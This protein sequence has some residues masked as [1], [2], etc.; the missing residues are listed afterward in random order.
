MCT[1]QAGEFKVVQSIM[2]SSIPLLTGWSTV[3]ELAVNHA[4]DEAT[5]SFGGPSGGYSGGNSVPF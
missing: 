2:E 5:N 1:L 4:L 3:L